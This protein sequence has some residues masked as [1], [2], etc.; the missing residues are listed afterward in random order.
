MNKNKHMPHVVAIVDYTHV[1]SAIASFQDLITVAHV[2]STNL[3][4]TFSFG[5][6]NCFQ[7]MGCFL[8]IDQCFGFCDIYIF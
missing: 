4:A 6:G 7:G 2:K 5:L 8:L 3:T 1:E